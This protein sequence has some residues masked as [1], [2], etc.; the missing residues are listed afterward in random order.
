MADTV[1]VT[2]TPPVMKSLRGRVRSGAGEKQNCS[3]EF[4]DQIANEGLSLH[5]CEVINGDPT[6]PHA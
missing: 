2:A 1:V 5:H 3:K 6:A 4:K